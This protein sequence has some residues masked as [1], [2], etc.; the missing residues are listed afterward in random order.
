[1]ALEVLTKEEE[2]PS[3]FLLGDKLIDPHMTGVK[4]YQPSDKWLFKHFWHKRL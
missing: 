2:S 4:A 1:M 3:F